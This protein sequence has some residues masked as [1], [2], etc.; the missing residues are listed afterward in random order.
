MEA[1]SA[2]K[3]PLEGEAQKDHQCTDFLGGQRVGME[4]GFSTMT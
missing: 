3:G 4:K 1:S 2:E